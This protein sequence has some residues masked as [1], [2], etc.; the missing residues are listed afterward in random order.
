M[1]DSFLYTKQEIDSNHVSNPLDIL[2]GHFDQN[3]RLSEKL[4]IFGTFFRENL[5]IWQ[6]LFLFFFWGGGGVKFC[7]SAIF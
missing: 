1:D 2:L 5:N 6:F 3:T 4:L 7:M